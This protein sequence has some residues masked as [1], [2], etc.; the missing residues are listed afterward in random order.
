MANKGLQFDQ[1]YY[2]NYF[3]RLSLKKED[4]N[5]VKF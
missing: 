3:S 5:K 4:L 2:K 1:I